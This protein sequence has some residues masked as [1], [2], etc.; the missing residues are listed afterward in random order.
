M[1]S[2]VTSF[3]R[4]GLSDWLWQR[5]SAVVLAIYT[6]FIVGVLLF[7]PDMSFEQWSALFSLAWVRIFSLLA[8]VSIVAHAWIGLWTVGTDY[9]VNKLA[10][11]LTYQTLVVLILFV[12]VVA[13][14]RTLWGV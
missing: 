2:N 13:S 7:N 10:L 3:G 6:L 9:L 12:Y 5:F 11:R 1:V 4:S 8:V 14:V